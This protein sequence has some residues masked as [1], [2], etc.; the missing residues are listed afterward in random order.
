MAAMRNSLLSRVAV[1]SMHS[2]VR[3][4]PEG[5]REWGMALLGEMGEITEPGTAGDNQDG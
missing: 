2:A 1:Q 3:V 5:S 4:W